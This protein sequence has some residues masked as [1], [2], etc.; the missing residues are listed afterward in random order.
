MARARGEGGRTGFRGGLKAG[1]IIL[2]IDQTEVFTPAELKSVIIE[3]AQPNQTVLLHV[4]WTNTQ[5]HMTIVLG[6]LASGRTRLLSRHGPA[7]PVF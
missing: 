1:D 6:E 5:F 4:L 2:A 7:C 3:A